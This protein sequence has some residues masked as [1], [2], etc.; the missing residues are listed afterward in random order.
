[1]FT[2]RSVCI[3]VC[4]CVRLRACTLCACVGVCSSISGAELYAFV[5]VTL[6]IRLCACTRCA[7]AIACVYLHGCVCRGVCVFVSVLNR[8]HL[9]V[10]ITHTHTGEHTVACIQVYLQCECV[11]TPVLVSA[12]V[13]LCLNASVFMFVRIR[14]YT[15]VC[16]CVC[17]YPCN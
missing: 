10:S 13:C 1:M 3:N 6:C 17:V 14:A 11:R 2:R 16:V 9:C 4:I 7:C 5:R 15:C 8:A 12:P